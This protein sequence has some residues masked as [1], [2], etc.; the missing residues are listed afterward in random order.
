MEKKGTIQEL[1]ADLLG[2]FNSKKL[3]Q[4]IILPFTIL[5]Q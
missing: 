3:T 2:L 1:E 4:K 5:L